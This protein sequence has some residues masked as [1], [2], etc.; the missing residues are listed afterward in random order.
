M[1]MEPEPAAPD[2]ARPAL[3]W[4]SGV[5]ASRQHRRPRH[6]GACGRFAGSFWRRMPN[7]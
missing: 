6:D 3:F 1:S 5:V 2:R 7:I 4:D